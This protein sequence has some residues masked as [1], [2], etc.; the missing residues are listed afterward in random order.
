MIFD[1][2]DS[3]HI[4]P[5]SVSPELSSVLECLV[6]FLSPAPGERDGVSQDKG[7]KSVRENVYSLGGEEAGRHCINTHYNISM[8][9]LLFEALCMRPVNPQ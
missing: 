8:I 1:V 7:V 2:E 9:A 5:A 4:L 3:A 6:I